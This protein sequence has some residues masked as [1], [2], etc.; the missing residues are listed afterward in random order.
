MCE[1][2]EAQRKNVAIKNFS[3]RPDSVIARAVTERFPYAFRPNCCPFCGRALQPWEQRPQGR[4]T[5]SLCTHDYNVLVPNNVGSYECLVCGSSLPDHKVRAQHGNPREISE[6]IHDG[7]CMHLWTLIHNVSIGESD[8]VEMFRQL[9]TD[10]H[11]CI[12]HPDHARFW[13]QPHLPPPRVR[14]L[15]PPPQPQVRYEPHRNVSPDR[16]PAKR[17]YK[18]KEVKQC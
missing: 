3:S 18:G 13:E 4:A 15:L 16:V 12:D 14:G 7:E 6:H 1:F 17:V 11:V 10:S 8:V 5:R 2:C 9:F